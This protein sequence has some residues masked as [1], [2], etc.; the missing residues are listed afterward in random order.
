MNSRH[1]FKYLVPLLNFDKEVFWVVGFN[2]NKEIC[3][4]DQIFSGTINR[5][6]VY[7][8]EIFRFALLNNA[9]EIVLAHTHTSRDLTPS[10]QDKAITQELHRQSK[11][12]DIKIV[13]HLI[14]YKDE[15]F[16]FF[17]HGILS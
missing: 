2:T 1:V 12:L 5:C 13:D 11:I 8:R 7:P 3:C 14:I 9:E 17:D 6:P 15:Y 4:A 10:F 16:S